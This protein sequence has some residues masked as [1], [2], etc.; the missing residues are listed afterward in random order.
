MLV[1]RHQKKLH[2]MALKKKKKKK[3]A[4]N[5]VCKMSK[6]LECMPVFGCGWG[7]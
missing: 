2:S 5:N 3:E 6:P 4:H 7:G 1:M